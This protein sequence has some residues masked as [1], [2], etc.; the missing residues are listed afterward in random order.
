MFGTKERV[1]WGPRE[2]TAWSETFQSYFESPWFLWKVTCGA[3]Y[4]VSSASRYA[5]LFDWWVAQTKQPWNWN[6]QFEIGNSIDFISNN[7]FKFSTNSLVKH[8]WI[9]I[10]KLTQSTIYAG[11][12]YIQLYRKTLVD[13]ILDCVKWLKG[14][15]QSTWSQKT[16]LTGDEDKF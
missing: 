1:G 11:R 4:L 15:L 7:R 2:L 16:G 6:Q 8:A 10:C 9:H 5:S 14:I 12:V 13:T 3:I